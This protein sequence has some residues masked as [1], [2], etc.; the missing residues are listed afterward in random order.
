MFDL[1]SNFSGA[2]PDSSTII[3]SIKSTEFDG[4]L[5]NLFASICERCNKVSYVPKHQLK[6]RKF[7]SV[8][9]RNIGKRKRT[10]I[11]CSQCG[12]KIEKTAFRLTVSKSGLLFCDRFCKEKAQQLDGLP[13]MRLPHYGTNDSTRSYRV[14]ALRAFG[15]KCKSCGYD[16]NEKMLD[17]DHVD[18][19]R[20]N[21]K[22][23]NLQVLCVWCHALKTRNVDIHNRMN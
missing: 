4:K 14:R 11:D 3:N 20:G 21:N 16:K 12:K 18:S 10:I 2:T 9:C 19:N 13:G 1:Q 5:R 23:E 17:V 15:S 7:C 22:L 6:K 8:E